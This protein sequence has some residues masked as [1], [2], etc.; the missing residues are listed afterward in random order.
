MKYLKSSQLFAAALVAAL[1]LGTFATLA[2]S[3]AAGSALQLIKKNKRP[4]ETVQPGE[5][6][7]EE[8]YRQI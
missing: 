2:F 3:Q 6:Q 8:P 5:K 7:Q 4:S 1:L